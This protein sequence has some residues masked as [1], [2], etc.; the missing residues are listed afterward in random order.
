MLQKIRKAVIPAAGL[1][2]RFLPVTKSVPKE[3]IPIIDKPM[4][5]YIV[6]EAIQ[7]GIQDIILIT[8]KNKESIEHYFDYNNEL[9]D[10]LMKS[11][12]VEL[13]Q[14]I[15]KIAESC[16]IISVYQKEP[17]G[18]GHAVGCAT[19]IVGKDRFAV[20]LGD[21][22]IDSAV[23]CTQQLIEVSEKY[24]SSVVAVME[25]PEA[26]VMKY[27]IVGGT[28]IEPKVMKVDR[29]VEKPKPGTAPSCFAIPGRYILDSEIFSFISNTKPGAGGEIQLTDALMDLAK[30]KGLMAYRFDGDRYDTGDRMGFL[31]ATL[32]YGLKRED[33]K[34]GLLSLMD[35]HLKRNAIKNILL[36]MTV[37]LFGFV[38]MTPTVK[39]SILPAEFIVSKTQSI[40]STLKKIELVG[41]VTDLANQ[42]VFD[43][44]RQ[45]DFIAG[46]EKI[47]LQDSSVPAVET[48]TLRLSELTDL[49]KIWLVFG[50]DPNLE[51][52]NAALTQFG[53][54]PKPNQLGKLV[55]SGKSIQWEWGV[56]QK[57]R[58]EKDKFWFSGYS[59][60][61]GDEV[62][63]D[64]FSSE[65]GIYRL[66]KKVIFRRGGVALF[67][68]ELI[69]FRM[70]SF[71]TTAPRTIATVEKS[72]NWIQVV[73]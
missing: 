22:L 68:Y 21:D 2:T 25:V 11:G 55:R 72:K 58:I 71:S 38:G 53:V 1:G 29:L 14:S 45:I 7:S 18:L 27:G 23:P 20:L 39:A 9:E 47:T 8:S 16:N 35:K 54:L 15:R 50:I 24:E 56:E 40:R 49:A 57:I 43:E 60:V 6:E 10:R 65:G 30:Q 51:R 31:D 13:A 46:T 66:P 44:T 41:R 67:S 70:N 19:P 5:H 36:A 17:L 3:M 61:E 34:K 63:V 69:R 26:D 4:I 73:R 28:F 37:G 62:H 48:H 42:S 59:N 32:T 64:A 12:K 33:L 52:L